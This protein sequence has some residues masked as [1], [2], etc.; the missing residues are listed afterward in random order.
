M[1]VSK[2]QLII[3]SLIGLSLVSFVLYRRYKDSKQA[4]YFFSKAIDSFAK[5]D[6]GKAEKYLAG[7]IKKSKHH[8]YYFAAF[9]LLWDQK[10]YN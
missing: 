5:N 8:K 4:E 2:N 1:I 7:A 3:F 6:S 10:K 9:K